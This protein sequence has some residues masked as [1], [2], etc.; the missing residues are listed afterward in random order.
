MLRGIV[1]EDAQD[2]NRQLPGIRRL[3]GIALFSV[4]FSAIPA[5]TPTL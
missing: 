5:L 4:T 3:L 2:V 1:V